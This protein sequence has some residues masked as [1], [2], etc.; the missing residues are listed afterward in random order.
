MAILTA[1]LKMEKV[2]NFKS[3]KKMK[4]QIKRHLEKLRK[5]LILI[6]F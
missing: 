2:G 6:S 3:L 1:E 5:L 4:H